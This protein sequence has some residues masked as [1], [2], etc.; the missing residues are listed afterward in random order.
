MEWRR[1]EFVNTASYRCF[2][3]RNFFFFFFSRN[4]DEEKDRKQES[5]TVSTAD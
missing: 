3:T 2:E 4:R 5:T 1:A